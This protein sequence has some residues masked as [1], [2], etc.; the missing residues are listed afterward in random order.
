M[1]G[2]E[3]LSRYALGLLIAARFGLD[4]RGIV[5]P[6]SAAS[7]APRPRDLRMT[8]GRADAALRTRA[9]GASEVMTEG[10]RE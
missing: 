5:P 3:A 1:V 10:N 4:P 6:P 7:P 8:T 2:P 9:R